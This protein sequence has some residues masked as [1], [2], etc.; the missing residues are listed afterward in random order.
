MKKCFKCKLSKELKYYYK[1]NMMQDGHLNKC[2]ECAKKENSENRNKKREYYVLYDKMRAN[3][4]HRIKARKEYSQS[5]RGKEV[6]IKSRKKWIQNNLEKR[7]AHIILGNRLRNKKIFK[8]DCEKC[9]DPK[10]QAHHKDYSKPLHVK[11]LCTK[12]HSFR[13]KVL[14]AKNKFIKE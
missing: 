1:H 10:S 2:K 7:A 13:H 8:K 9:G 5:I 11:W 12:C 14:E 4:P 3:L 6:L